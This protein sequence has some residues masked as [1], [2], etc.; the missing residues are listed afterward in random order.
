MKLHLINSDELQVPEPSI[1]GAYLSAAE[2]QTSQKF[3]HLDSQNR[4]IIS[5]LFCRTVLAQTL[6]ISAPEIKLA[7]SASGKPYLT[8]D[9]SGLHFNLSHSGPWVALGVS[10]CGPLGVDIEYVQKKRPLLK[11]AEQYFHEQ[12]IAKLKNLSTAQQ[13]TEFYR[14]WTLKEAFFKA[15]GTGISE[16]LNKVSF[17]HKNHPR[18]PLSMSAAHW[19]YHYFPPR[20]NS[21]PNLHLAAVSSEPEFEWATHQNLPNL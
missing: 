15:R 8:N 13:E 12:E 11:I 7:R 10:Q 18:A 21:P 20:E 3:R 16:G 5:R 14:L 19:H 4:Y 2:Q 17:A 9:E 6:N 1:W